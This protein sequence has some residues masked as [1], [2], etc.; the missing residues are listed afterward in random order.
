MANREDGRFGRLIVQ[1]NG[2][3][4]A[5][6]DRDVSNSL[7]RQLLSRGV[8]AV[9]GHY[10]STA[11]REGEILAL[12]SMDP[13]ATADPEAAMELEQRAAAF[14]EHL[15]AARASGDSAT[16]P[17]LLNEYVQLLAQ[18][19]QNPRRIVFHP[20]LFGRELAWSPA[21]VD[22]WF[23]NLQD[24]S[25]E[26]QLTNGGRPMPSHLISID[27]G[28]AGAGTWQLFERNS[29]VAC[30]CCPSHRPVLW[31]ARLKVHAATSRFPCSLST[32]APRAVPRRERDVPSRN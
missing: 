32:R 24:L 5:A 15:E 14:E 18:L 12:M 23:N 29:D 22:F 8:A 20:A 27:F 25:D 17:A 3:R 10:G 7:R 26:A 31:W 11:F 4:Q 13:F 1:L 30:R 9:G 6:C 2:G 16:V 28:E 21:R 19:Q